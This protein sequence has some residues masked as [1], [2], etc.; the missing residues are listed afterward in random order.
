MV[1]NIYTRV[2][3]DVNNKPL[4][5]E[6]GE[7]NEP[8]ANRVY[9]MRVRRSV[10]QMRSIIAFLGILFFYQTSNVQ[11][12]R[13]CLEALVNQYV[14]AL[15]AHDPGRLPLAPNARYTEN[16][17]ELKLGD[18]MWGPAVKFLDYKFYF[19]D[20]QGGQVGFFGTLEE[21]GHPAILGLRLK[22]AD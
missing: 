16:G 13:T 7:R 8:I 11:C 20:P 1:S 3:S 5:H 18:G 6:I 17:I 22:I 15:V 19:A 21:H 14:D 2:V 12:N 9:S 4:I 10:N